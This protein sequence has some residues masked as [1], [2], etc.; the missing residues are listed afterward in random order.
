MRLASVKAPFVAEIVSF[1]RL[2]AISTLT[3]STAGRQ[4]GTRDF[5]N[6]VAM[7]HTIRAERAVF[8]HSVLTL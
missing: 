6:L 3:V 5:R 4:C 8:E 1:A 2:R 7:F